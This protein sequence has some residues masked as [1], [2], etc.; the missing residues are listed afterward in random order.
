FMAWTAIPFASMPTWLLR[1]SWLLV[2]LGCLVVL[3]RGAWQLAGGSPLEGD[4]PAP[5]AEQFAALAGVLAGACYLRNC[6]AH[7]QTDVVIGAVLVAGCLQLGRGRAALA[8]TWFGAAA[9]CKCTALLWLPYFLWRGQ[10]RAAAWLLCVTVGLNL[11]PD[12]VSASPSGRP[13]LVEYAQRYLAPM[14]ASDY[15]VGTWGS[16]LVY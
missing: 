16:A 11:L 13:W 2:N 9:A 3:V 5:R 14:T 6:L 10:W 7:Q 1:S 15:Y 4:R 8:A 12:L